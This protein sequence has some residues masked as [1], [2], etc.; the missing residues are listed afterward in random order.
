MESIC[1]VCGKLVRGKRYTV[2]RPSDTKPVELCEEHWREELVKLFGF[3]PGASKS[4][5]RELGKG[6]GSGRNVC[7]RGG[8]CPGVSRE[9]L[10]SAAAEK[11]K[12]LV[13]LI[14]YQAEVMILAGLVMVIMWV[15]G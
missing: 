11:H 12:Q 2:A 13:R 9:G 3:G 1:E 7:H 8:G 6:G 5:A 15:V 14:K 10:P 4:G